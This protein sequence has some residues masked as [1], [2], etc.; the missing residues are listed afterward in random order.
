MFVEPAVEDTTT[1]N[2]VVL[3][4]AIMCLN[5]VVFALLTNIYQRWTRIL[6]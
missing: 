2:L 4:V 3:R 1:P 5:F 6:L